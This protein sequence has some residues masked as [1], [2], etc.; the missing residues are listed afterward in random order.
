MKISQIKTEQAIGRLLC[1]DITRIEK[2]SFKGAQFKKGHRICPEDVEVLLNL[3]KN[4]IYVLE[5]EKGD[6]HED[7]AGERIAQALAGQGLE[8]TRPS[9][10]RVD[11]VARHR[12]LLK[13]DA[14]RLFQINSIPEVVVST[15]HTN[16][17]VDAGEKVTGAKVIPLVVNE[18]VI[19]SVEE[20]CASH[21]PLIQ[22]L[23]YLN[24]KMGSVITGREV[25][26]GRI[27]DGF[28]PVLKNKAAHYGLDEPVIRY[29]SDD[30]AKITA[31][32]D[33]L[34]A[35]GCNM[36]V[37]TGGM[38]VDP[39]DVTPT[40]IKDTGAEIIKYGAPA[41]PGAMF[42]LAYKGGIPLIGLP[43]CGMYYK[44]T[45][46]DILMPRLMTGQKVSAAEIAALGH[47][48]LCR[49]CEICIFPNCSFG[50]G[51]L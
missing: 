19:T 14:A 46:F 44:N 36:I 20:I 12:G 22:V 38:S 49:Q 5:L 13:V 35:E 32:I 6:I 30:T 31:S 15:L 34:I 4:F 7:G 26:E 37:I 40:G 2:D 50:K 23:P 9:E 11:L 48:G 18:S 8:I 41:L 10:G 42:L 17:P 33:E 51:N 39:D 3:G 1:H 45:V 24:F 29:C 43:A 16:S 47:G 27:K 28:G 25:F 21:G